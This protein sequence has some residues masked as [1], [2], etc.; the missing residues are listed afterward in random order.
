MGSNGNGKGIY[1]EP[2]NDWVLIK[3]V[4]LREMKLSSGIIMPEM[5]N[6]NLRGE[7]VA[8]GPGQLI[9]DGEKGS[10]LRLPMT[11]KPGDRVLIDGQAAGHYVGE[12]HLLQVREGQISAIVRGEGDAD[13]VDPLRHVKNQERRIQ[14]AKLVPVKAS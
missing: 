10:F 2:L 5:D 14:P 11:V 1:A 3:V 6:Q 8:V 12:Q 4:A 13:D 7:V 9:V